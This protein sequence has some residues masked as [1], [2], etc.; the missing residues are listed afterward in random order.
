MAGEG[1][2]PMVAGEGHT[3]NGRRWP[4]K[5]GVQRHCPGGRPHCM[6]AA[7]EALRECARACACACA[8]AC[9]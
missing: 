5:A 8:C 7:T 1:C 9:A 6:R 4:A 3:N 2:T